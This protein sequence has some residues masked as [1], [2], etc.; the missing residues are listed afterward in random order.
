[1]KS[2]NTG[3]TNSTRTSITYHRSRFM[4]HLKSGWR[5]RA[6]T[7]MLILLIVSLGMSAV[8]MRKA[9][10]FNPTV[11]VDDGVDGGGPVIVTATAGTTG[12]TNYATLGLAF[13]AINAGTHQGAIT[14]SILA[15]TTEAGATVLNSSGA[16]TA[17][18]TTV[19][20][21]PT[22]DGVT[23][24]GPTVAGRGL[25]E[26][27]GAD[28]VTIDGDNP[29]SMGTNRNLTIQNTAANTV[30]FASVI[31]IALAATVVT[32]ADN[33]T[34]RNLNVVGNATGRNVAAATSTAGTENTTF[35]IVATSGASTV[36]A[37]TAPAAITSVTA[38]IGTGATAT[39]LLIQNNSI[40]ITARAVSINGSATTVFPGLQITGNTIGNATAA[41]LDQVYAIGITAQGSADGLIAGN[42]VYVE[43]F[44]ASSS[45]GHAINVGVVSATGTFTIEK[46]RVARVRNNNP[47]GWSAF[48]INLGGANNHT[49]RN[50]FIFD[51]RNDQTAGTGAFGT[52]FGA[53]G[54]RIASGTGHKIYHNSVHLSGV[55][56]GAVST[57]LTVAFVITSTTLTGIDVRNNIFSNQLTGGNPTAAST[58]HAV[59]FLPSAATVAMNLTINNN[60]YFQGPNAT[61][62]LSLLAQ[63]GATAGAGEFFAANFNAGATTPANNL[64]AYT[65]TLSAAGTNDNASLAVVGAPPFVSDTDLHIPAGTPTRLESGGAPVGVTDDID[66]EMR[67][68]TTPDIGADEFAGVPPPPNDIAAAA[69]V[70]PA[71]GGLVSAGT[72]VT[73]QASFTNVGTAT[74]N[75]VMVQFTI[76]GP[77][78]FNYTNTQTIATIAPLQS[79]TVTFAVT[80]TFT[81]V[82]T[83]NSTATVTTAD[84]N[85]ANNT[86][87]GT[88]T[89]A[90]PVS[91][92][93]NAGTGETFTSL[94]NPGGVF[95]A[96][97]GLGAAS[98]VTV[99]IT[100]NLTAETGAISL[101]PVAGG[102]TVTIQPSGGAARTI[103]GS[104][105][106]AL[107]NLNGAD[108]VTINGL[109]T[110]GNSLLIRNT[111]AG[112]TIRLINDASNN[113]IQN[114][115]IEGAGTAVILLSTGT[116][117]GNDNNTISGNTV[118]D[119]TAPA[120]VPA[121]LV[122]SIAT[123]A[124]A[125]TGT[126]VTNNNLIN[127]TTNGVNI[128]LGNENINITGNDISQTAARTT[129]IV[130][131]N[132][133]E[134][135]GTGSTISQNTIHDL[136]TSALGGTFL[137]TA[138]IFILDSR[139]MT[140][141]R[142]RIHSFPAVAGAT[143]R[144]VGIE[145]EGAETLPSSI[146]V[147]N[148]MVSI[149]TQV[150]TAQSVFGIF[151]FAF[152]GNT[153]TADHNSVYIGGTASGAANSWAFNRGAAA[154]T[155]Y[156]ARNNIAFNDR[157][158]GTGNHFAGGD[159]SG[160]TGTFVS[161]FNFFAGTGVTPANFMDYSP[162]S[163]AG[164][165]VSF[166]T[167][168]AG[169]PARDANS[170]AGVASTFNANNFFVNRAIGDLHLLATA[171]PVLDAGTPLASVTTDFDNQPRS[172]TAPDIGADE[173]SIAAPGTL[174]FDMATYT[175]GEAAGTATVT[176][177][178]TG[179]SDGTVSIDAAT[180]AGGTATG[181]VACT[182]GVDYINANSTLTFGP[183]VTS[184]PFNI[185]ICNDTANEPN[186][187]INLALSN[188]QGGAT[189]GM[190][191]TAVLTITDNDPLRAISINNLRVVEGN[192]GT[193]V[194]QFT[195]TLTGQLGPPVSVHYST[196]DGTAIAGSDYAGI[197]DTTINF[198]PT[199]TDGNAGTLT[200]F[201]SVQ[202]FGDT[203][204]EAN[205]TFFIN[206]SNATNAN[207]VD[208]QGVCIIID[209]DRAYASDFDHDRMSDFVV[210]RPSEGVWYTMQSTNG[211][212]NYRFF[213]ANGDR[214][215]PGDYD[216]DAAMDLAVFRSS[217]ATWYVEQSS[218]FG[219][220]QKQW[221]LGSDKAVQGDYDRD[222]KT[223]ITVFRNGEWYIIESGK[224]IIRTTLFG[225][226]GDKPVPA[227]YDGDARTDLAVVR[228]GVWHILRSSDGTLVSRNWGLPSDK[229]VPA[230]YDG[231]G[232]TDIAVFRNGEW[233]IL[234][235]LTGNIRA[236]LWGQAG[237][238]PVM[239]DYD[240]NGTSDIAVFRNGDWY[241]LTS[242]FTDSTVLTRHWGQAGDIP[243]AS[244]YIPEH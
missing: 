135:F 118:R 146:V 212:T 48:G 234:E 221:G 88:F 114:S 129:V 150:A 96:L 178:R 182:A 27:N 164:T 41:A 184:Q 136:R 60:A 73:P 202:I 25:I 74:Q 97:N 72:T 122:S 196:S 137:N 241:I 217:N 82:G 50:N 23:I 102:F 233:Y 207:I 243:A 162:T 59:L 242:D 187:T 56:P 134:A 61:G 156:T 214:P 38:V 238:I 158:G 40:G 103:S 244:A 195:V 112:S 232:S 208:A 131:I 223:D 99:N 55:L 139:S 177:T 104:G 209:D 67:N 230:D 8:I 39:N 128:G 216:G 165:P 37:T 91:G 65:S 54:I 154:P 210:F 22:N 201:I 188:A 138:G 93:I 205:E 7:L 240:G 120:G 5:P 36:A 133:T 124:I 10:A 180:V 160:G 98:N 171:T 69:L 155:N 185:T 121:N 132:V 11:P 123:A 75:N 231:D 90:A 167:W 87:A 191:S 80:P 51:I 107:I 62:A 18:Y 222:G 149:I 43:G 109:N 228:N 237:D 151:D 192:D 95:D 2:P 79:V 42:T 147:V 92:S 236:Q 113:T 176:V 30:N 3:T 9:A 166:A 57:N 189:T 35:G 152:G 127:F 144:I 117:T 199:L 1:M 108:G 24:A 77:G 4:S 34:I 17:S 159:Q 179:G 21:R 116:T 172:A 193:T 13:D 12:P 110:G 227:D 94:T 220:V 28:N 153:F 215:V 218:N 239:A 130:G 89:V 211:F 16:G 45:A 14:V 140:V 141:S 143:G 53:Y 219:F 78:G 86:V 46:N 32:S 198:N 203:F 115:T 49:V 26:L 66:A 183:G 197:A 181:G 226:A 101:N 58:R 224:N 81:T 225:L 64:R 105:A 163:G 20:I 83:Y 148:N 68:A 170:I 47:Q 194:A 206:L 190:Q 71:N 186:E 204:K 31:R 52:T 168:Q 200:A 29:N 84:A 33:C 229:L 70:V 174:Q 142:N 63:V 235:S 161:N 6:A 126:A 19:L 173:F 213:G 125:N 119:R 145:Y 44:I 157:T 76:T 111:G 85:P 175:V 169:P 106:T 15:S 100:T